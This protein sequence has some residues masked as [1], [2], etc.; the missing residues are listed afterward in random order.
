M[1]IADIIII[2]ICLVI[3]IVLILFYYNIVDPRKDA[4]DSCNDHWV[5]EVKRMTICLDQTKRI[6][7]FNLSTLNYSSN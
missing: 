4:I 3:L 2:G 6:P 5:N 1:K 7:L